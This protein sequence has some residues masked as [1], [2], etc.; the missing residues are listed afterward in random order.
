MGLFSGLTKWTRDLVVVLSLGT[1][2]HYA[3]EAIDPPGVDFK[4]TPPVVNPAPAA[5]RQTPEPGTPTV[6]PKP[7]S[8]PLDDTRPTTT[9]N[10]SRSVADRRA[11]MNRSGSTTTGPTSFYAERLAQEGNGA[12]PPSASSTSPTLNLPAAAGAA[13]EARRRQAVAAGTATSPAESS[14]V[15]FQ[16]GGQGSG[17]R[18]WHE[19]WGARVGE[20]I[21]VAVGVGIALGMRRRE[22]SQAT[23]KRLLDKAAAESSDFNRLA[24]LMREGR[25]SIESV[26]RYCTLRDTN[27]RAQIEQAKLI[28][29]PSAL[30]IENST[31]AAKGLAENRLLGQYLIGAETKGAFAEYFPL[32]MKRRAGNLNV[33]TE[34]PR[35]EEMRKS[36]VDWQIAQLG[37]KN[38]PFTLSAGRLNPG[39]QRL[40]NELQVE[41]ARLEESIASRAKNDFSKPHPVGVRHPDVGSA[42]VRPTNHPD[43]K[44]PGVHHDEPKPS[45]S[46]T[47][48]P[49]TRPG[50]ETR[51]DPESRPDPRGAGGGPSDVALN[52]RDKN[53]Y[54]RPEAPRNDG[55]TEEFGGQS[56]PPHRTDLVTRARDNDLSDAWQ[57]TGPVVHVYI[58]PAPQAALPAPQAALPAPQAALPAPSRALPAPP[59]PSE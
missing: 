24:D 29:S 45:S 6:D 13:A 49:E 7:T 2:G 15:T 50:P 4:D 17:V 38:G 27:L 18:G 41:Q 28:K 9:S 37:G 58:E 51:P 23:L 59:K 56:S 1:A 14:V 32:E 30:D 34:L 12:A 33:K 19:G 40:L 16:G 48:D 44:R 11:Q 35:Y 52:V 54:K 31:I 20:A 55:P 3:G 39:E 36:F 10:A 8:A 22:K 57:H 25:L 5:A 47:P 21:G 26:A 46:T 43:G 42:F 53:L